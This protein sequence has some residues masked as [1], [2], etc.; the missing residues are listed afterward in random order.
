MRGTDMTGG[1]M[2]PMAPG[3]TPGYAALML[4]MWTVMT[5]LAGLVVAAVGVYQ[6]TPLKRL[7]HG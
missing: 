6:L 3:W 2:I 5:T 1:G 4:G 7:A